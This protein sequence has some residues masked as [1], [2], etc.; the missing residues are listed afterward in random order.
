VLVGGLAAGIH[1]EPRATLDADLIAFLPEDDLDR[2]M[3]VARRHGVRFSAAAI[4]HG[5]TKDAFFRMR[6]GGL[7]VDF[8]V[9][10]SAF[11]FD[12]LTRRQWVNL[13]GVRV[14]VATP[15]D[16]IL[17]KLVAGRP[18]DWQDARAV[19]ARHGD[20]LDGRYMSGWAKEL[21]VQ[22][23]RGRAIRRLARLRAMRYREAP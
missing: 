13:F 8:L 19:L 11:E 1:G 6:I 9:G 3:A 20:R 12:V 22:R 14:P 10:R 15:E 2:L 23:G 4:R 21:R 18:Q 7:Q 16:V 17:M 5:A